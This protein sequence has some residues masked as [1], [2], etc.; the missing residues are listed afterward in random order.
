MRRFQERLYP[1]VGQFFDVKRTLYKGRSRFQQIEILETARVGR[2]LVLDGVVQTTEADE[3]A[4]HEML[5]H[6]PILAHG[7]A[8]NVLI[9]GGG[10]G[11]MLEEVLKHKSVK[12]AVLAEI[13]QAVID[14]CKEYL[15]SICGRAF[16]DRRTELFVGDGAQ[17]IRD[18][19]VRFDIIILDRPDPVG[20]AE[21]LFVKPFYDACKS[22]LRNG[23]ILAAQNGVPI[24]Q[25]DEL[26][27][28]AKILRSVFAKAGAYVAAIPTY[29]GGLMALTWASDRCDVGAVSRATLE[30]RFRRSGIKTRYYNPAV[31]AAAFQLP[32][33]IQA[34]A[35]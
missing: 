3:F 9:I 25:P 1:D 32:T 15:P 27:A 17:Y 13:D 6:V 30:H 5:T 33:Y 31:H 29:Y 10:D 23:G 26:K 14:R 8:E 22:R 16:V 24:F 11:G 21:V 34:L 7:R 4:Y 12:K 20:L 28:A 35:G 2:M 19:D 18:T